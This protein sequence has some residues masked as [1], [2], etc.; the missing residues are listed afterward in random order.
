VIRRNLKRELRQT[1]C[2]E[3]TVVSGQVMQ[4]GRLRRTIVSA[5]P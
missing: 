5:I 2:R 4:F 3:W 1:A